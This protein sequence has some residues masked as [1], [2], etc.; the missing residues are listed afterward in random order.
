MVTGKHVWLSKSSHLC[1][2]LRI[3]KCIKIMCVSVSFHPCVHVR[4]HM[5]VCMYL[6]LELKMN[7]E[8]L[9][10]KGVNRNE[11]RFDND[12]RPVYIQLRGSPVTHAV[13]FNL[14]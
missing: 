13:S 9:M 6:F 8:T 5:R 2:I 4:M 12:D 11:S 3:K 1:F 10:C 14:S 7:S